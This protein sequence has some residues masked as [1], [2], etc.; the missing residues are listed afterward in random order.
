MLTGAALS[1][2][3]PLPAIESFFGNPVMDAPRLSPSGRYI[4]VRITPRGQR[5]Q[6]AVID[7]ASGKAAVVA[8]F[9][10][11]D[12]GRVEW[13]TDDR[14][15]Y[16]TADSS[17]GEGDVTMMPGV[18]AV[19]RDGSN[20][21]QLVNV[22]GARQ[23]TGSRV[24]ERT[25]NWN[26]GLLPQMPAGATDD[27]Y[28]A[29]YDIDTASEV[30]GLS[31]VRVNTATGTAR[32]FDGPGRVDS[33]LLDAQGEPRLAGRID[34]RQLTWSIR[35]GE[36]W[37]PIATFDAYGPSHGAFTP[38][39]FGPDGTLYVVTSLGSDTS[40]V[41]IFD[42]AAGRIR[43]EPLVSLKGYDF[44]GDLL[45]GNGRLLGI[46]MRTDAV[47]IEWLDAGMKAVQAEV[48]RQLPATVN[49]IDVPRR[50][51]SANVLV[52]AY[53][54]VIPASYYLYDTEKKAMS[55]L[56]DSHPA[57]D[58][59]QMGRQQWV[60]YPARDGLTIP[61]LLTLPRTQPAQKLPLVVLVHGGPYVRGASWGWEAQNQFLASR[62][63]AVLQ[64]EFRGSK[65]FGTRHFVAGFKQWGLAMQ[66]D[67]TDG[68]R[69]LVAKGI[70]DPQRVC[71]AG[72]SYGGYATLMGLV[73]EPALFKCGVD[74]AGVTDIEL[75]YTGSWTRSSDMGDSWKQ[76]GMPQLV[77]DRV[78]D[79]AQLK[80]TSP[81]LQ[82]ARIRQP[83]LLAYGGADRRVPLDHGIRLRDAV[84]QHNRNVEW[85]EYPEEGHGWSLPQNRYD[86]WGRVERFLDR[87][88]GAGAQKPG[89]A[90]KPE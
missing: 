40:S 9:T 84:A 65:G 44:D 73:R 22:H 43:P 59:A 50:P 7:P 67:L 82:A 26:H 77:G 28:L 32:P 35:D 56:G 45:F 13:L 10:D 24:G 79:A 5:K 75:L 89:A 58:P 4:A 78:T 12:V 29:R 83:L 14:L 63:Y 69:W 87:N 21:R 42:L 49:V 55:K 64:P 72:A 76:Y 23:I 38:L 18:F 31:L 6:L 20:P 3:A 71:I 66:D 11:A 46:G 37:R 70:V 16:D 48:D 57:I 15:V 53:S 1:R 30:R 90:A 19:N 68:V 34:G 62:G 52:K 86:F 36:Q 60:Q 2:A 8:Q 41:H 33:W 88:I 61:G 74:W 54:D 80:A 85:V 25:L 27:I 39:A 51:Q 47:G 17:V 81:V